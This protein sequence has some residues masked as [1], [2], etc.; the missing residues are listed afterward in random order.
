MRRRLLKNEFC[1]E[2]RGGTRVKKK[3]DKNRSF[4]FI[5]RLNII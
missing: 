1:L 2:L 5:E 4:N 3:E